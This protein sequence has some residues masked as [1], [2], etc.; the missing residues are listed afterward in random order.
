MLTANNSSGN[1]VSSSVD[2]VAFSH[3]ARFWMILPFYV[4][5]LI[6]SLFVLYHYI[7]NRTLRQ[8]LHNHVIIILLSIN[9]VVQLT[10]IPWNLSYY[11]LEYVSPQSQ[12]F[13]IIWIVVDEG[14]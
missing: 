9:L 13:C 3:Y 2:P 14:L 12:L 10:G 11:R 5:S 8:A 7:T 1:G 4:P 6:C